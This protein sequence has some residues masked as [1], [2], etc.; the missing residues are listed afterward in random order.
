MSVDDFNALVSERIQATIDLED[1]E[2][3]CNLAGVVFPG[4]ICFANDCPLPAISFR[5][6]SFEG[7]TYFRDATF[8]G[9]TSFTGAKFGGK[10][11]FGYATFE[12]YTNFGNTTFEEYTDFR[13][14]TFEGK[15]Y[16]GYAKFGGAT[17]FWSATFERKTYFTDATFERGTY[18]RNAAFEKP[19]T[20]KDIQTAPGSAFSLHNATFAQGPVYFHNWKGMDKTL[21]DFNGVLNVGD[22]HF[23]NCQWPEE[24][25]RIK[26]AVEDED[27]QLQATRDF[28][29]R[30]KRKYKDEHN[31]YEASRWHVS[32]KE[33]QLKLLKQNHGSWFLIAM[34]WIYKYISGFGENPTRA[35]V[36]LLD[37]ALAPFVALTLQEVWH[38][39]SWSLD[40]TKVDAVI[41]NW[42][43]YIP[44][45]KS[46]AGTTHGLYRVL[47]LAWQLLVTIQA[48]LFGFA[49]RNRFRR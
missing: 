45:A 2:A 9:E 29:Q 13:N 6:A 34:L 42:L 36:V 27:G 41:D 39:F 28:Y 3:I 23:E 31:E 15:T 17:Y 21:L 10:T 43:N 16:F 33:A 22:I 35:I 7:E 49:L 24:K 20:F 1:K 4:D 38:H 25:N 40:P 5:H 18:F 44:L 46:K 37:F 14:A 47:T 19:C 26:V 11:Y 48:T 8:G 12:E 32:E 30:M